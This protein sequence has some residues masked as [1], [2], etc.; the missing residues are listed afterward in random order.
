MDQLRTI[1]ADAVAA[2]GLRRVVLSKPV[3]GSSA[4]RQTVR[5]VTLR[6]EPAYQFSL[7][8]ADRETH[9][10]VAAA[11]LAESNT[12]DDQ[13]FVGQSARFGTGAF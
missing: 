5:P 13:A 2:R 10:N 6:G 8:M 7:Q 12:D 11:E 3:G 9:R 4:M 1:L